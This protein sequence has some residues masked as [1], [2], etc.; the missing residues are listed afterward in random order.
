MADSQ[1]TSRADAR[2]E[3]EDRTPTRPS[4]GSQVARCRN[5]N[6]KNLQVAHLFRSPELAHLFQEEPRSTRPSQARSQRHNLPE[7]FVLD[8]QSSERDFD[9][10]ENFGRELWQARRRFP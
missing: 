2:K 8:L 1:S 10:A 3:C 7:R 5:A 6:A 9:R 4:Y